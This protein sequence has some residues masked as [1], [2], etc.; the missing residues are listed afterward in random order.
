MLVKIGRAV[1]EVEWS[2]GE[3]NIS[4]SDGECDGDNKPTTSPAK[5]GISPL[6]HSNSPAR[7]RK[8]D[9][10]QPPQLIVTSAKQVK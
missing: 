8:Q 7:Y 3:D 4:N 6:K 2:E 1:L 9:A 10:V 5:F